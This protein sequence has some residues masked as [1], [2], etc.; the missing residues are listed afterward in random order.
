[1]NFPNCV[2]LWFS[3][4]VGTIRRRVIDIEK[5]FACDRDYVLLAKFE[6]LG[7]F[8]TERK[9]LRRPAENSPPKLAPLG[10]TGI[11][12]LTLPVFLPSAS[13][14]TRVVSPSASTFTL[15]RRPARLYHF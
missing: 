2:F 3:S 4:S 5:R 7:C 10:P 1:M 12:A 15:T 11:S 6:P 13:L 8:E 14:S 9:A